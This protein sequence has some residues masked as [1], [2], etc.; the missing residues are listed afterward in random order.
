LD[1]PQHIELHVELQLLAQGNMRRF[2]VTVKLEVQENNQGRSVSMVL[3]ESQDD[4]SVGQRLLGNVVD[5][6]GQLAMDITGAEATGGG[7]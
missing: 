6:F 2:G 4:P 3:P 5:A 7:G 1:A